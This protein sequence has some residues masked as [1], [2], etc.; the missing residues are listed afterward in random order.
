MNRCHQGV[1]NAVWGL[2]ALAAGGASQ[3]ASFTAANEAELISAI[4][5]ANASTDP[6]STITL[7][8]PFTVTTAL[9]PIRGNVSVSPGGFTT[10]IESVGGASM[11]F[12]AGAGYG[13]LGN[14]QVGHT[15]GTTG[16][17]T[18]QG[19]GTA[20]TATSLLGQAGQAHIRVLDGAVLTSTGPSGVR[21]G[22]TSP[23]VSSGG[24]ADV[25]VSGAGSTLSST[26]LYI[27]QRGTLE[28][29]AGGT[30]EGAVLHLGSM[31]GGFTGRVTGAGSRLMSNVAAINLG[32]SG[33][34]SLT[35]ADGAT[36]SANSGASAINLATNVGGSAILNIGGAVGQAAV[37]PG[38]VIASAVNG[39]AGTAVLNFNHNAS[40]YNF[41]PAITGSTSLNHVGS[42]TT[43]LT[44]ASTHS[45]ATTIT[46]GTLR[47]GVA[48]A[49]SAASAH[50]VGA[51][52]ALDA[53]QFNQTLT[54]LNNA[55][56]VSLPGGTLTMT[57]AYVGNGGTLLL[58]TAPGAGGLA[59]G[60]LVLD[61]AGASATGTTL[62]GIANAGGLGAP[63]TG[64]GIE[65]ITATGGASTTAQTSRD[66][67]R[68]ADGV[69]GG[70]AY[71]YRLYA[72]D[73]SGAGENW[74]LRSEGYRAEVPLYAV[75][76]EQFR[77]LDIAMLGNR[78]Q[79]IGASRATTDSA[80]FER[81]GWGRV[82]SVDRDIAQQGTVNPT[83]S[84][85]LTGFQAGTDLWA[86]TNWRAG[87]YLGQLDG[88]M[89][90]GG[91]ASGAANYA[92]GRNGL[93]SQYLGAY[94]TW[95]REGLSLDA[96]LQLG[97]HR[98]T[99]TPAQ[100]ASS[101]GKGDSQTASVE[102]GQGFA[103]SPRWQLEPTVQLAY[104]RLSLDDTGLSGATVQQDTD[105]SW[106]VR[107]GVRV[108]G[109]FDAGP[110]ALR[111]YASVNLH[112]RSNSTDITRFVGGAGG[113]DI[114]SR[115]GGN[116]TELSAGATWRL[117]PRVSLFGE[118]SQLWELG[119]NA[120]TDSG[121]S[122]SAGVRVLW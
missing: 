49:F 118:V 120:R 79:R 75:V 116:S 114:V 65:V 109:L 53:G 86:D 60:R 59:S 71:Q 36:V 5:Q 17:L 44:R 74:Y 82:F 39:G 57:G 69:V 31:P 51:S 15:A 7:T 50:T 11:A 76:P 89:D 92:A 21:F 13:T 14:L 54:T 42:G 121:V 96:V 29:S 32:A 117:S 98:Y 47:A 106:I 95:Q 100:G 101:A 77:A 70:G 67:F 103:L 102:V 83:S 122:G 20:V 41:V 4:N 27:H 25:L 37:A 24:V 61:G 85:R 30:L 40:A 34:A 16:A 112:K 88:D 93:R 2:T 68:L 3:A 94:A 64:D 81:E 66:A 19:V 23:T 18:V 119:G 62:V 110:G 45:G 107:A 91:Q 9:P 78:Q 99:A 35:V 73:A 12:Q 105:G 1:W 111:P 33:S 108:T 63:T 56:T 55:G 58:G 48:N 90:V 38:A 113:T 115:T 87:L 6:S 72:A 43:T 28:V 52:G 10:A 22:G 26:V 97:H 80:G 8:A 104:Q 84:G 46:G